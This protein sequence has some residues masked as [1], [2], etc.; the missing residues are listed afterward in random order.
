MAEGTHLGQLIQTDIR[1]IPC[2]MVLQSAAEGKEA[3]VGT[4]VVMLFGSKQRL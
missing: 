4:V 3:N 2:H 1:D